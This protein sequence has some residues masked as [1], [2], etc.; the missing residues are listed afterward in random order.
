M[1]QSLIDSEEAAFAIR[2]GDADGRVLERAAEPL[3]ALAQRLLGPL[4]SVMS[5]AMLERRRVPPPGSRW[6]M[7]TWETGI[8]RP[9]WPSTAALLAQEPSRI[10][11]GIPSSWTIRLAQSGRPREIGQSPNAPSSGR[12]RTRRASWLK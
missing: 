5:R 8:S 11:A 2:V 10:A 1:S 3:L 9:S 4:A 12:P 7:I 6:A